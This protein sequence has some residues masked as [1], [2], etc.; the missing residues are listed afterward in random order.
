M[1]SN[2]PV[3]NLALTYFLV[4]TSKTF[5]L[6]KLRKDTKLYFEFASKVLGPSLPRDL[7]LVV[8]KL[9]D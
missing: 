5:L 9:Q 4:E 2:G 3:V 1:Q 7:Q 6:P 8:V